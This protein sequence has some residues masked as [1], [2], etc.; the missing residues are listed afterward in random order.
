MTALT[1]GILGMQ[2][3]S[4]PLTMPNDP[5]A[6]QIALRNCAYPLD[7]ARLVFIRD[8]LTLDHLWVSANLRAAVEAHPRLSIIEEVPL[9]FDA[10][11]TMTGPWSLA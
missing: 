8:T 6:L 2:R 7:E 5:T 9:T 3:T 4:L 1:A 10:H 11:G